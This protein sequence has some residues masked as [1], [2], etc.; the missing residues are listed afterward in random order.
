MAL[1]RRFRRGDVPYPDQAPGTDM[2]P[3]IK[4]IVVLMMQGHSSDNY[5]GTLIERGDGLTLGVD[6]LPVNS[7]PASNG[8]RV[9]AHHLPSTAQ[10]A[11]ASIDT[12]VAS[13]ARAGPPPA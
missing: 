4:Y 9:P 11:N 13:A 12:L 7:N 8:L 3:K 10:R 6:G 5:L 2:I 1:S